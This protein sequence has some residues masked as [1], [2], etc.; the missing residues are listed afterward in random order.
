MYSI[1]FDVDG[2]LWDSTAVVA[3]SWN[4]AI[5]KACGIEAGLDEAKLKKLFGKTM[6]EIG[7]I[8]LPSLSEAERSRVC[9]ECFSYEN[10]YLKDHPGVF[11]DGAVETL[12]KLAETNDLYIVSNCQKGYIDVVLEHMG[13]GDKIKAFLCNGDN[14]LPKGDN[15]KLIMKQNNVA[16]AVYVGDIQG[17]SDAAHAAGIPMVY[18]S[19]GFGDVKDAEYRIDDIKEL[20]QLIARLDASS[21]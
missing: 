5:K 9:E 19:Y 12:A 18:A 3:E 15:I 20:P 21:K 4:H 1:I 8:M 13:I 11:Y 10:E 14:N 6:D 16:K 17:D 7:R 2:T